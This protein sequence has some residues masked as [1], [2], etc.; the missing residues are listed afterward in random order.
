MRGT[1]RLLI[2][3]IIIM[4][5]VSSNPVAPQT[6]AQTPTLRIG[7]PAQGNLSATAPTQNWQVQIEDG[8]ILTFIA[9]RVTGDLDPTITLLAPDG[10][11]FKENDDRLTPLI[12]DAG[13]ESVEFSESGLYTVQVGRYAGAGDYQVWVLPSY[14]RV[15]ENED[16]SGDLARW[17]DGRFAS[18]QEGRL[19]LATDAQF[20]IFVKP[21]GGLPLDNFYV[22]AEFDWQSVPDD[23]EATTGLMVRINDDGTRR[24][25]GYYFLI[26][27]NGTWSFLKR[28]GEEFEALQEDIPADVLN[29]ERITLGVW[30]LNSRFLLY[31]NG[32]L[33][34]EVIDETFE[35]G[36]W[37][38]H[39][40]GETANAQ[41]A[42]D[43]LLLTVPSE[44]LPDFPEQLTTWE[45]NQPND[46][47]GELQDAEILS[48]AG[49]RTYILLN[50]NYDVGAVQT[51]IFEQSLIDTNL[52]DFVM[53]VDMFVISG[54]NVAC[55]VTMRYQSDINQMFTYMDVDGGAGFA[56]V[57][58]GSFVRSTYDFLPEIEVEDIESG[59]RQ[60]LLV[61]AQ[62]D[63][64]A[65][66]ANGKLFSLEYVPPVQGDVGGILINYSTTAAA[67]GY[68]NL[69]IWR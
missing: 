23:V 16:F 61:I 49:S 68:E 53:G 12:Y 19:I 39:I 8:D 45:S 21:D 24:P 69:W 6:S 54:D 62:G 47:V 65:M 40:R 27:P 18:Q 56:H 20:S 1:I 29:D 58:N 17:D 52:A 11:V 57:L 60:R 31:A 37:G 10:A 26:K 35:T 50:Q 22:Q 9:N 48:T 55:G 30:S 67:C 46:I 51:R 42:V 64:V 33:L 5:M 7:I 43:D 32:E 59:V 44:A 34:G 66:Y 28:F 63:V 14:A 36:L 25:P 13:L 38:F 4:S 15:W 3:A 2:G 41:V